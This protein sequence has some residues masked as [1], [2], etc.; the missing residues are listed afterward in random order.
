MLVN[1]AGN[2]YAGYFE[3]IS[4]DD[5]RAQIETNFFG[6]LNVTRAVLPVMR[7]QRS[8]LRRHDLLDSRH[9]R[10]GVQLRLRRIEVR[11]RGLD[12]VDHA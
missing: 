11:H 6:P 10:P 9:R 5:F 3:E 4:P 1:N 12:G 7:A 2:F 8:G